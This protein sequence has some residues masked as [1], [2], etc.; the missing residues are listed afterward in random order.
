[1]L[2]EFLQQAI[3]RVIRH[4][5]S[6][7]AC[8]FE[9]NVRVLRHREPNFHHRA[10]SRAALSL[11]FC[12]VCSGKVELDR[13]FFTKLMDVPVIE[14]DLDRFVAWVVVEYF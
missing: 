13:R 7:S 11:K 10:S 9:Q 1:M 12:L 5:I 4:L 8:L 3:E 14:L 2:P 6:V